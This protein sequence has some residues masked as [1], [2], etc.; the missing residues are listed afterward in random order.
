MS[1]KKENQVVQD[2]HERSV[3]HDTDQKED[4]EERQTA[5]TAV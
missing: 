5:K 1:H 4:W 2:R 3:K